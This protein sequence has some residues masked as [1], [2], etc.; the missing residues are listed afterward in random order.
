[1]RRGNWEGP[2]VLDLYVVNTRQIFLRSENMATSV[3]TGNVVKVYTGQ[4]RWDG[5]EKLALQVVVKKKEIVGDSDLAFAE[6]RQEAVSLI[7]RGVQMS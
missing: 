7:P 3:G 2:E 1:M 6:E 5:A 4:Q